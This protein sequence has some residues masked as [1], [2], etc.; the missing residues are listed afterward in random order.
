MTERSTITED[1]L[2]LQ[3]RTTAALQTRS[4]PCTQDFLC[5]ENG[6]SFELWKS[7]SIISI[8]FKIVGTNTF[9]T[10]RALKTLQHC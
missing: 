7:R 5:L 9:H 3:R 10:R 2:K 8:Y 1:Q 4:H 6:A